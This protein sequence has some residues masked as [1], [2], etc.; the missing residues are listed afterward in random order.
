MVGSIL[1]YLLGPNVVKRVLKRGG[2]EDESQRRDMTVE[3]EEAMDFADRGA[4]CQG[5]KKASRS[6]KN[7]ETDPFSLHPPE[8]CSP[9][10]IL[11]LAP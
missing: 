8:E 10:N 3:T 7:R 4:T 2:W 5:V 6:W 11:V 1:D 9:T